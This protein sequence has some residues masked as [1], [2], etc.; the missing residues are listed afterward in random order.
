MNERE[1]G[2]SASLAPIGAG[3]TARLVGAAIGAVTGILTTSISVRLLGLTDY[4]ALAFA[5]SL[6]ALA[7]GFARLGLAAGTAR[8]V[9]AFNV[10]GNGEEVERTIRGAITILFVSGL[11]GAVTIVAVLQ[12]APEGLSSN[13]RWTVGVSLGV[14]L[15]GS[16]VATSA[17]FL[18]RG[19]GRMG[20]MEVPPATIGI[21]RFAAVAT[22]SLLGIAD[23]RAVAIGYGAAALVAM[24]VSGVIARRLLAGARQIFRPAP[25]AAR[26]LLSAVAPITLMGFASITISR[27][28][29]LVLGFTG[30]TTEVGIYEP[31][32]RIVDKLLF[33]APLMFEAG[34]LPEATRLFTSGDHEGFRNLYITVTK[35]A[36]IV[37]FPAI[38]VLTAFPEP[39]LRI[40]YGPEFPVRPSIVW[41]LIAGHSVNLACGLNWMVLVAT[42]HRRALTLS[43][44]A[45]FGSAA[46]LAVTLVPAFGA[47]GA[48]AAT[49]GGLLI[50]NLVAGYWLM[51]NERVHPFRRDMVTT[52]LA[53]GVAIATGV[54]IRE[55]LH[56]AGLLPAL[57]WTVVITLLW[58]GTILSLRSTSISEW[59]SLLPSR[60]RA[61]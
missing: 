52:I 11:A 19:L 24:W 13:V 47:I 26:R 1:R 51:R 56:P 59:R 34:M 53:A 3:A 4:G 23:I 50:L 40:L 48:A 32:L 17:A 27:L 7:A 41:L 9:A 55:T 58:V 2:G 8:A 37:S 38:L 28:D 44:A 39:V 16:N 15:V 36:F 30:T 46:V 45:I 60:G 57:V 10:S 49:A 54:G 5:F 43:S 22:L 20:L 12:F 6:T 18:A 21:V 14:M 25:E 31:T 29:V 61:A 35:L 33:L 42:G